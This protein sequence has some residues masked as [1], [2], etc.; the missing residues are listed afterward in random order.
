MNERMV[1]SKTHR[2]QRVGQ[3]NW[4]VSV[5]RGMK[6]CSTIFRRAERRAAELGLRKCGDS[7]AHSSWMIGVWKLRTWREKQ[8]GIWLM[9]EAEV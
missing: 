3:T 8:G 2:S 1:S 9:Q 6:R 7:A 5:L 4:E